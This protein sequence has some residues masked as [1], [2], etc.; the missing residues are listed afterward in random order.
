[1][2][3]D[4][5]ELEI[6]ECQLQKFGSKYRDIFK[7]KSLDK[8]YCLKDVNL[9][10]EGYSTLEKYSYFY[11]TFYPCL[12][13]TKDGIPCKDLSEIE[14][15]FQSNKLEFKMQ[16]IELTPQI[17]NSPSQPQEKDIEGPVFKNLFQRIYAYL[18]IVN[19]ET[20]EEILGFEG[21][22]NTEVQKF[23]KYDESWIITAPSPHINGFVNSPICDVTVQLS[24]KVLTQR[25]TNTKL[26]EVLWDVGGIME[27][28]H[29]FFN[30]I[31]IFLT[32][33]LYEKS[34]INNLF[35]FDLDKNVIKIKDNKNFN[36]YIKDNN[37]F[38][39]N[40]YKKIYDKFDTSKKHLPNKKPKIYS[41]DEISDQAKNILNNNCLNS[42]FTPEKI[43]SNKKKIKRKRK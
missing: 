16:D 1:M 12:G 43:F 21:L 28:V 17:Y 5:K 7:D 36:N 24:A 33:I 2:E 15:F 26:I 42:N 41:I 30:I 32:D 14:K 38:N 40:S 10:L 8:L 39:N 9:I 6:E 19:L 34:L 11:L 18:Q 25:R 20:D 13:H 27:V 22:S 31:A 37:I 23:L 4:I 35:S 29:S 3:F